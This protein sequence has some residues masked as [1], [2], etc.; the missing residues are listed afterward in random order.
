[1]PIV[2]HHGYQ[3]TNIFKLNRGVK[4]IINQK[5]N[6]QMETQTTVLA[7]NLK[8]PEG[9]RWHDGKLWF[10][11]YATR[12]VMHVDLQGNIQTVVEV[13]DLPTAFDWTPD[14]RLLIVSSGQRRLLTLKDGNLVT[15]ADM[16]GL[17]PYNCGELVVDGQGRAYVGNAGYDVFEFGPGYQ[18][19]PKTGPLLLVTPE[20]D[21]RIVAEGMA[22]PNGMVIT[23]DGKTLLVA[24]SHAARITAFTTES[25]G[26]LSGRWGWAQFDENARENR[27]VPDGMSLDADE[28]LWVASPPTQEL[29]HVREGAEIVN[30]IPLDTFPLACMLGGA[31]RCTLF[32]LTT[33][34]L[35]PGDPNVRGRIET[36]QVDV[37]GAGM[38]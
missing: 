20:G 24:E 34:M 32:I 29:L 27:I 2:N 9:P 35:N 19:P 21:A 16:S 10:T 13:P 15:F 1:M 17:V 37:P 6:S 28:A 38:P 36:I 5:R 3:P 4:V 31:D 14:G 18:S 23:P 11:D 8:F 25:D 7:D 12:R 26:S 33:E 30:R 22:F